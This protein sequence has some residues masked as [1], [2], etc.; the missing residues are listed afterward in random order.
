LWPSPKVLELIEESIFRQPETNAEAFNMHAYRELLMLYSVA[1]E[2]ISPEPK[3]SA[4]HQGFELPKTPADNANS[5]L[6]KFDSTAI[7][8]LSANMEDKQ[9]VA[10]APAMEPLPKST[11]P[12]AS[13]NLGLDL[14]LSQPMPAS[15]KFGAIDAPK[16]PDAEFSFEPDNDSRSALPSIGSEQRGVNRQAQDA[17][18]LIDFDPFDA[19]LNSGEKL[20]LPKR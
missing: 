2:I 10:E 11:I 13:F 15:A 9:A 14:D 7:Q 17:P 3:V 16:V 6:T 12:P 8:P 4:K 20:K 1:K 5:R 18:N 19:A